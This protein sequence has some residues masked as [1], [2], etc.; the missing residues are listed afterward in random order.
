MGRCNYSVQLILV[1]GSMA[2]RECKSLIPVDTPKSKAGALEMHRRVVVALACQHPFN[3]EVAV[4]VKTVK[5]TSDIG[6]CEVLRETF[7]HS[8]GTVSEI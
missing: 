4:M 2:T 1:S 6:G 3:D 8:D 7:I 5:Y